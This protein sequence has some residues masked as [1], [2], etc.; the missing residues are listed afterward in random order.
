M[1]TFKWALYSIMGIMWLIV[2][3]V[4]GI[5]LILCIPFAIGAFLFVEGMIS[6]AL[7]E[8]SLISKINDGVYTLRTRHDGE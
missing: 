1:T 8:Q 3:M 2:G 6:V 7:D 4:V 5:P